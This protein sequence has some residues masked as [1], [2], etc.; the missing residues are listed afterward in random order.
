MDAAEV[1]ECTDVLIVGCGP[2]GA[3]L[4]GLLGQF[5]IQNIIVEK[6]P[7]ITDDPRGI[8]LDEDGIRILQGL[9]LYDKIYTDIGTSLG[10]VNF[11]TS[12]NNL[13]ERPFLR[14]DMDTT[15]GGT[16][17]VG[18]ISHCQPILEKHL[19]Q[20]I[21]SHPSSQLRCSSTVTEIHEDDKW[22]YC[23]YEGAS[24][25][26]KTI[27]SKY[28]VGCDGKTGFVRKCYM[29]P[30]GITMDPISSFG[31]NETWVAINLEV[32][33]PTPESHPNLPVWDRGYSSEQVYDLYF[34]RD[35]RFICNAERPAVCG[36]FGNGQRRLWRFEFVVRRGEDAATMA[37]IENAMD[38]VHPYLTLPGSSFGVPEFEV[39]FP[40]DCINI[41]RCRPFAFSA[42]TCNRWAA[43]R[44]MLAGDA[45]HVF[46]PFGGQGIASGFRDASGLAWRLVVAVKHDVADHHLLLSGWYRERQQQLHVSLSTTV[47]NGK[48]C[49]E[50][51]TWTFAILKLYFWLMQFVPPCKR[52][53][54]KGERLKGM[55]RYRWQDGLHF[56]D[57][58]FGG[59]SLPQV[60]CAQISLSAADA[61]VFLTDDLIFRHGKRG[62]FQ[63]VVLPRTIEE[64]KFIKHTLAD[65][66]VLSGGCIIRN[67]ATFIIQ[68]SKEVHVPDDI[69]SNVFRLAT[70]DEFEHTKSLCQGRP[71][72]RHY[73]MFRLGSDLCGKRFVVVR[74]DR[75]VYAACDT[76]EQLQTVCL[77]V[78]R[79]VGLR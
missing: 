54:E 47:A 57:D 68:T 51:N 18:A 23:Q 52:L 24:G 20:I 1:P 15:E 42:R 32:F 69:S 53:L 59:M 65:L 28:L 41:L 38:I 7:A 56:V 58:G 13:H 39:K 35:F 11:I 70:A 33:P 76:A 22:V 14:M 25:A 74:P 26:L 21:A 55:V 45:A 50:G 66:D 72:P 12:R 17:H 34:P 48:L 71:A 61:S 67:E 30:K 75:F 43:G 63:L 60:Y 3:M 73:D 37:E 79:T 10:V 4:S 78:G 77:G 44:V 5:G 19:R 9:G 8:T 27:R 64:L 2:T 36:R 16:G 29:E 6:Q 49:T 31:Y 40:F 62:I 46:P